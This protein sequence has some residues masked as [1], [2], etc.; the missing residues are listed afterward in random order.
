MTMLGAVA[1]RAPAPQRAPLLEQ[2]AALLGETRQVLLVETDRQRVTAAA[3]WV[4]DA[5][6]PE[7]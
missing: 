4:R 6:R 2:A 5:M 7:G 1:A 3:A